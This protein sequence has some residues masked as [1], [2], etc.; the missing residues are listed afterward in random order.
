MADLPASAPLPNSPAQTTT[1][2]DDDEQQYRRQDQCVHPSAS[3]A[4]LPTLVLAGGRR[5]ASR[6][7]NIVQLAEYSAT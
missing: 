4:S 3:F 5:C 6:T 7:S 2:A 1:G